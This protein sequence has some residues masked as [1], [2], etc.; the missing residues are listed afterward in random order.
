MVPTTRVTDIAHGTIDPRNESKQRWVDSH[1]DMDRRGETVTER[2]YRL[3]IALLHI[4]PEIW[5]TFLVPADITLDRLH[6]VIQIVMGWADSHLFEFSIG[7][8]RYTEDPESNEDGRECGKYRLID[9]LN[10]KGRSF[11]YLYDFGDSWTHQILIEDPRVS[12]SPNLISP[13]YCIDGRRACP[14]EDVGGAPGYENFLEAL[15]NSDHEEHDDFVQWS[16]GGFDGER[17]DTDLVNWQ[18]IKYLRHSRDRWL[19]W[20]S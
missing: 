13:L 4:E 9:L 1:Q 12:I 16:G 5:R 10:R 6:D 7:K 20:S 2:L 8:H 18:L 19:R 3:R 17:F 11:S 14:P 15:A